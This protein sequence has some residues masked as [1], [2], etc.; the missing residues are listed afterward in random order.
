MTGLQD[1][2][3]AQYLRIEEIPERLDEQHF[4]TTKTL[5]FLLHPN[6]PTTS[7]TLK[8]ADIGTG[9]GVW[10]L[11]VATSLPPTCQLTGFDITASTFPARQSWPPNVC[12]KAQDMLLPFPA[13]EIGTYDVV[14]ARFVSS[15]STR[16]EWS[17]TIANLS[18]L[19]KP[20]GWLQWIDSC[21]FAL[22][23][24]V[25]GTS[26]AACQ[27]I[28]DGLEPFRA[29][30]DLVIGLMMREP[31]NAR[32]ED[33]L[34]GLGFVD[35]HEDVFSTDRLQD[36]KLQLREKGTRNILS[37]FLGCLEELAGVEGSDWNKERV[38][39]LREAAMKEVDNGVYHTLDQVC[40]VGR[41]ASR[42]G[43]YP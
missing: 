37:C 26:R 33:V 15:A 42:V 9:T 14:A 38:E 40:I 1:P 25:A 43:I 22:Y 19:L 28:Y 27:E 5:G 30:D 11:D 32:R 3:S 36:P 18:T 20:G 24:S 13:S 35:V 10:L 21:N 4:F 17:R 31:A 8:I 29:K 7:P 16:A 23:N 41:K 34:R 2:D 12:F 6:I 39:R